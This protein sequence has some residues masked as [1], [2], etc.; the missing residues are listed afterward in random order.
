MCGV[1]GG[2]GSTC[3]LSRNTFQKTLRNFGEFAPKSVSIASILVANYIYLYTTL[4]LRTTGGGV[5]GVN[6]C[7]TSALT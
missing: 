2:G 7:K 1:C 6:D 3:T 5:L 4:E